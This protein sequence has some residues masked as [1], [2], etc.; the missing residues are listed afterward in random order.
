MQLAT[1]PTFYRPPPTTK[2]DPLRVRFAPYVERSVLDMLDPERIDA[3]A[4]DMRVVKRHRKHHSGLLV[5]GLILSAF[6]QSEVEGRWLDAAAFYREMGGPE[7]GTTSI[8]NMGRKMLPVMQKMLQRRMKQLA[9]EAKTSELRGR[10]EAF[11]DVLIPDGCAFKLASVLSGI[12]PGTG[13]PAEL[14][15]HTV[16][17]VKARTAVEVTPTAG[18]V[19]DSDGFWPTWQAGALYITDLGYQNVDRFVEGALANAHLLQRLKSNH[20]PEIVASYGP[21]GARRVVRDADG[22][23]VRL[24]EALAMGL[25]HRSEQLDLD[26]R[27]VDSKGRTVIA[28]VVCV[29]TEGEDRYYLTTLLRSV[30]TPC[31]IAELYRIRWEVELFFRNWKGGVR[32]DHVHRL[33]NPTSLAVAVTAS[34]LAALLS[35]DLHAALEALNETPTPKISE[36]KDPVPSSMDG[37]SPCGIVAR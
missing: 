4:E 19:H 26:V 2:P 36:F 20:N 28:R 12:S 24:E 5:C 14:K 16:Y 1:T 9:E 13:Q 21:T 3:L 34:M 25:V 17:S 33:R 31:D 6:H 11:H 18:S 27:L 22:C 29:P 8:R 10:L 32:M 23:S 37:F 30:F 35:R 15:L 7:T